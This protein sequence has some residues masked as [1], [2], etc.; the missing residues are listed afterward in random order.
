M[1]P[2]GHY[3]FPLAEF[4]QNEG[5]KVVV[6]NPHHVMQRL[7]QISFETESIR[8]LNCLLMCTLI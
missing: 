7:S 8:S 4:L 2:T 1:E 6:V 3:W 5:I